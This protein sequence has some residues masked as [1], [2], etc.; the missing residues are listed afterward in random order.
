MTTCSLETYT[1]IGFK[2]MG[3]NGE[4]GQ[5]GIGD[6]NLAG[7]L[8]MNQGDDEVTQGQWRFWHHWPTASLF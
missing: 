8:T 1:I 3:L 4:G 5:S 7:A 2:V 6:G